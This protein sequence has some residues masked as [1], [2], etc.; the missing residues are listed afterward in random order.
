MKETQQIVATIFGLGFLFIAIFFVLHSLGYG[1]AVL[2]SAIVVPLGFIV[3]G[4]IGI[5]MTWRQERP[6]QGKASA[7]KPRDNQETGTDK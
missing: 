1:P 2:R 6:N 4:A 3:I 5:L 7:K